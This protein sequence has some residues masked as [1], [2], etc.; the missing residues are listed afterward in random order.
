[1][2][3]VL[4]TMLFLPGKEQ[5]IGEWQAW[6]KIGKNNLGLREPSCE[7]VT[8][9]GN[10]QMDFVVRNPLGGKGQEHTWPERYFY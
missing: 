3:S 6:G 4:F 8:F 10:K 5:G 7:K 2:D 9:L 1:M